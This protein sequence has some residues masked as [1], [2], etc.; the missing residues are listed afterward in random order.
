MIEFDE[1]SA[2]KDIYQIH[3]HVCWY[4]LQRF[5]GRHH[6][7]FADIHQR[8]QVVKDLCQ[9]YEKCLPL[10]KHFKETEICPN[11]AYIMLAGQILWDLWIETKEDKYFWKAIVQLTH[12]QKNS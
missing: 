12:T 3:R 8:C 11:D 9:A 10:V 2:P 4:Q 1:S 7:P 6:P 5:L